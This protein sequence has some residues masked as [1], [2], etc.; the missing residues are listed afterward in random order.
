MESPNRR[1][2]ARARPLLGARGRP[3]GAMAAPEGGP[4]VAPRRAS[5]LVALLLAACCVLAAGLLLPP[6]LIAQLE[7]ELLRGGVLVEGSERSVLELPPGAP[8]SAFANHGYSL[9]LDELGRAVVSVDLEPIGVSAPFQGRQAQRRRGS[10]ELDDS[11]PIGRLARHLTAGSATTYQASSRLLGWISRNVL[12]ELD[13]ERSQAAVDVLERRSGYCT[14]IA[15]LAVAMH[16]AVGLSARE[17][18]GLVFDEVTPG[19]H[20]WIET[21]LAPGVRVFSDPLRF[22]HYV[23]AHFVPL[24]GERI[25]GGAA[26]VADRVLDR[27]GALQAIDLYIAGRPG[28]SARRDSAR[29]GFAALVLELE[30]GGG[31]ELQAVL[32]GSRWTRTTAFEDGRAAF[33]GLTPGRYGVSIE[34]AG[35]EILGLRLRG[36]ELLR[37]E[38]PASPGVG[39]PSRR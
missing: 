20:R 17:V 23:P 10:D 27:Q 12:Y 14:G 6:R 13:R 33:L 37:V 28:V 25:Q 36:T 15:A 30:D 31:G 1:L 26:T 8:V 38:V 11:A 9:E 4:L 3:A 32:E 18:P 34:P 29:R 39:R 21:E 5:R 22:H 7:P 16:R 19:Y 35:R 2:T 24:A